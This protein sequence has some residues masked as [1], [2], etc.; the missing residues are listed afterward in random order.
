MHFTSSA[1]FISFLLS[2]PANIQDSIVKEELILF[3]APVMEQLWFARNK[4]IHEG[5]EFCSVKS[6][7]V[8][9]NKFQ[10]LRFA[11]SSVSSVNPRRVNVNWVRPKQGSIK[12]NCDAAEGSNHSFIA[13]VSR[14]W[15]G[16]LVFALSKRVEANFPLQAEAEA[17]K[18]AS[19]VAAGHGLARFVIESDAKTCIEA[20]LS[21]SDE[22]HW[23]ISVISADTLNWASQIQ[24]LGFRWCPREGNKAAHVLASWCFKYN[25]SGCFVERSAPSVVLNVILVEQAHVGPL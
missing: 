19:R 17:I 18:W 9:R 22:V 15:R 16:D 13:L 23:R 10:E 21:P 20:L 3:G 6:L 4:L 2:P 24:F 11:F 25:F 1:Q 5:K 8:V 14:N 12:I 7:Q